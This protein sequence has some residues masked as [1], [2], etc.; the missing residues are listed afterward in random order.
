LSKR[1]GG[2]IGTDLSPERESEVGGR[3]SSRFLSADNYAQKGW[4]D[5]FHHFRVWS[6][7][8]GRLSS[9]PQ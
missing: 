7:S 4:L 5:G 9:R 3:M 8:V 6:C 1:F 2:D